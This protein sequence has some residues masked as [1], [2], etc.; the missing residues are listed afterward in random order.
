MGKLYDEL[1]RHIA[2]LNVPE[3]EK[4][5]IL[6]LLLEETKS[7]AN[8]LIT[9]ATG[10]GKSS[11]IN[12][13]FNTEVAKVGT[14]TEP[15]TMDITKYELGH[16][17]LWDSPG[18]GD[19]VEADK[20]HGTGIRELLMKKDENGELLIDIVLVILDGS[21]RDMGTS[22]ELI[23]TIIAPCLQDNKRL[24][25]GIN[26]ADQAMKGRHW[27]N[28]THKPE[29]ELMQFLKEKEE[30][31]SKRIKEGT[32]ITVKPVSYAAGFKEEGKKQEPSYNLSKLLLYIMESIPAEKRLNVADHLNEDKA[33]WTS[34]DEIE[35]YGQRI[36]ES[37]QESIIKKIGGV[38]AGISAGAAAGAA[39]GS[40]IPGIGTAIGAAAGAVVGGVISFIG[41]FFD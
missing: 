36:G 39:L 28:E 15:E 17:T 21:S 12:A 24:I 7:K 8:I 41:S 40:V 13:L 22:Y 9:G 29:P 26:Q 11:T 31:V 23:R 14:S 6:K 2:E 18:L 37:I 34:N 20:R 16:L 25:I 5:K 38:G 27:N 4:Q 30:S 3:E 19:G 33:M 35:D 10:C 32:G 1:T